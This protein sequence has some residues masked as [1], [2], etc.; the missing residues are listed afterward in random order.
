M[1]SA[2]AAATAGPMASLS[3]A[4]TIRASAPWLI[5]LSISVSCLE[6]DDWASAEIYWAPAASRAALIA[7]SSVF[8]RSSWKLF[9]DTPTTMESCARTAP[10]ITVEASKT[11]AKSLFINVLPRVV[12]TQNGTRSPHIPRLTAYPEHYFQ[13]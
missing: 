11:A 7:P 3:W 9:Q 5:R 4:R 10:V 6:A 8:Q 13:C 12:Q 2:T 1:P